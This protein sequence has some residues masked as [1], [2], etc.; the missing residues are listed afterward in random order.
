[1]QVPHRFLHTQTLLE[2]CKTRGCWKNKVTP[3]E[4]DKH[5]SYCKHPLDD[6]YGQTIPQCMR[7]VTPD[8]VAEAVL[9]YYE[10][11]SLE[12]L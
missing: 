7:M 9:S 11:G 10:E 2:C 1:M 12:K 8:I 4:K 3:A 6:G 5:R